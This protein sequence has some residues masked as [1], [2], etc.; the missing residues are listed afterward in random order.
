[1]T[2]LS[3]HVRAATWDERAAIFAVFSTL[4]LCTGAWAAALP[5]LKL[6]LALSDGQL[7]LALFGLAGGCVAATLVTGAVAARI[8]TGRAT[9]VGA[10]AVLAALCLP[11]LAG[12]LLA[13]TAAAVAFG[14]GCGFVDVSMNGHASALEERWGTPIMSSLHGG[15][16]LGGL[17]GAAL[18]G[19]LAAGDWSTAAR[20]WIPVGIAALMTV[21]A[22]PRLGP[23]PRT[24]RPAKRGFGLALPGRALIGLGIVA[25]FC[26][27]V[28]GAVGDWS[29]IY[30]DRV[31][32]SGLATA[33]AGYAAF[34]IAMA[35]VRF[36][37]DRAVA[38]LGARRIVVGGGLLAAAGLALAVLVPMPL[39]AS[40]GFA[41]VGLGLGNVAPVAFGLAARTGS[42]PA[43][44]VAP[45][46]SLGYLGFMCGPP[47]IGFLAGAMGLRLALTCLIV[48]P[49]AV[50]LVGRQGIG[51]R[52]RM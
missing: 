24:P 33:A 29:A 9:A 47:L 28:E 48:A 46:A 50:A 13:F 12:S 15:F 38:I 25:A 27:V 6:Q 51:R 23:G 14:A 40:V 11:P 21:L 7:G 1:M 5:A 19:A 8:G 42:T 36:A 30:L 16:S 52:S 41:L 39:V 26:F 31:A 22:L 49:A 44:G 37:G 43:G 18:G 2:T 32:G 45:V 17:A 3:R 20:L 10:L 4:G 35:A 34:S